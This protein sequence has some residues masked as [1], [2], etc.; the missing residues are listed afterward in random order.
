VKWL[1]NKRQVCRNVTRL[2][3]EL[4][5]VLRAHGTTVKPGDYFSEFG[6][7]GSADHVFLLSLQNTSTAQ[8][9]P[10]TGAVSTLVFKHDKIHYHV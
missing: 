8:K 9:L 10:S 3:N 7:F 1:C 5:Q 4:L 6:G 2:L